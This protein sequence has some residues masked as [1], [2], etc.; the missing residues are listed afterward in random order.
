MVDETDNR[1][2]TLI[3]VIL[4]SIFAEIYSCQA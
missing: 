3:Q 2:G 4:L 1:D